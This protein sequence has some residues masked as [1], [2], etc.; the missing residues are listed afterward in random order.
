M[1]NLSVVLIT[2]NEEK[3]IEK[4]IRD[5]K[6]VVPNAEIVVVDSSKDRTPD[7][8]KQLGCNVIR[9]FP[10]QGYGNAMILA[11]T[12]ATNDI[13]VT[14]DCDDTYPTEKITDLVEWINK[15]Y[16]VVNATR[17]SKRPKNMPFGN[18]LA[19]WFFA[20]LT[21]IMFGINT[22]DVHSGMRAYK[23][24]VIHSLTWEPNGA[25]LPVELLIKPVINGYKFKEVEIDYNERIGTPTVN[26]LDS[27]KWTLKRIFK[28]KFN[29]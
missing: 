7:I 13:I 27:V 3:A 19:N 24:E 21:K 22:T 18:Y 16:D 20:K 9:Q 1:Q 4:V 17:L 28:L 8:A 15:G 25:A 5:I 12:S 2:L 10:P 26:K 11:L 6:N 14:L 23:K 29:S